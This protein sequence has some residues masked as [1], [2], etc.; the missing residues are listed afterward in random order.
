MGKT[1]F[2][3]PGQ[4]SQYVG[5]GKELYENFAVARETF[6]EANEALGFGLQS[7]C[8][9]GPEEE[10]RLT[11]NTQP[12][13][14][15]VSIAA[16]R[17]LREELGWEADYLAGHSLGEFTALVAAEAMSFRDAVRMVRLRGRL[18]QEAVPVGAGGMAAVLGLDREQVE[19]ICQRAAQGE[20]LTPANFNSPGQ[21]VV[22]GHIKAIERGIVLAKE[23]G[24]KKAVLLQVSAPFHSPLMECAGQKLG[25]QLAKIEVK[26]LK[27]PVVTNVEAEA[28]LSKDRVRD[29]LVRQVSN[30]VRWEESICKMIGWGVERF[31]EIGPGRVLSGLMR[32]IDGRKEILRLG[33]LVSLEE[34]KDLS[35]RPLA[36]RQERRKN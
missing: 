16:L 13:I 2:I 32:R 31:V 30:P 25:A 5:M 36:E 28:N 12:S 8:F 7:L 21:I 14:L 15:T 26:E 18:M 33:D 4:G 9:Q 6:T 17:V 34:L 29:L 27:V 19:E 24:A 11:A 35:K 22:S 20:V 1:A 10:L 3:F 23:M